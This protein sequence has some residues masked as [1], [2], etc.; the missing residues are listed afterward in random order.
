[1][2]IR[3]IKPE[4]WASEDVAPLSYFDRLLFIG[5]WSY[6]DDNGVGRDNI[7]LIVASLFPLEED[8][9]DIVEAV[10]KG[11][12]AIADAGLIVRYVVAQRPYF[13][14]L[15]WSKHQKINRPTRSRYPRPPD[16]L[17][18]GSRQ[19]PEESSEPQED[20]ED[21]HEDSWRAQ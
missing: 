15:K 12:A 16:N 18:E 9:A 4:F 13:Y 10:D 11:V 14:V 7:R 8:P 20:S 17:I 5:L 3:T 1:M 2:R 6:V 21:L 19:L